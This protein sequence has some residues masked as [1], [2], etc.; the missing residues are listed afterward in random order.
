MITKTK[1]DFIYTQLKMLSPCRKLYTITRFGSIPFILYPSNNERFVAFRKA[2]VKA[3]PNLAG[4]SFET[5]VMINKAYA[6]AYKENKKMV[7]I[8]C[9]ESFDFHIE[10]ARKKLGEEFYNSMIEELKKRLK[11]YKMEVYL[12]DE[13]NPT[14]IFINEDTVY[15]SI[16]HAGSTFGTIIY[17]KEASD[18]YTHVFEDRAER[19]IPLKGYLKELSKKK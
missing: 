9:K 19:G 8:V 13:F 3:R 18:I 15:A 12:I 6:E 16:V 4:S 7:A 17:S 14:Q 1:E 5:A 11:D 2:V 10:L